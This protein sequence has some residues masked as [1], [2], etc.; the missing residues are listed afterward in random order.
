MSVSLAFELKSIRAKLVRLLEVYQSI[1]QVQVPIS[2]W[3][4][5]DDTIPSPLSCVRPYWIEKFNALASQYQSLMKELTLALDSAVL[6]PSKAEGN[7]DQSK[8]IL[9]LT[10]I[11]DDLC[12]PGS[13]AEV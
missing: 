5:K 2:E 10:Y 3:Y 4:P 8:R 7:T 11:N 1:N 6:E 12:S 13:A 9:C